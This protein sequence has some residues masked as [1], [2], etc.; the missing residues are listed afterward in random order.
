M[1]TSGY[2]YEHVTST[3]LSEDV[4]FG[5]DASGPG[6]HL[7]AF[8]PPS[9]DG[10][11]IRSA[12]HVG[13]RPLLLVTGSLTCPM[14]VSSKP[15]LKDLHEKFGSEI[16]FVM[17]HV[18]EAHPGRRRD[19]PRSF[20]KKMERAWALKRRDRLPWPIAVDDS[21][22]TVHRSRDEKPNAVCLADR[23]G[24]IVYRGPWAG[25]GKGLT[26]ALESVAAGEI[27]KPQERRRRFTPMAMGLGVVREMARKSGPR[28][29]RDLRCAALI[30]LV[31]GAQRRARPDPARSPAKRS[32]AGSG[33]VGEPRTYHLASFP[34]RHHLP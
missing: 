29:E 1:S 5:K 27:P 3:V 31:S 20:E 21:R 34:N 24:V 32:R 11:R 16:A 8:D 28:A 12:D 18:R 4:S 15:V 13:H 6:L 9:T 17:P 19:R 22:G 25:D 14:T 10:G 33:D 7:P 2:V 23:G 26:Q 30:S